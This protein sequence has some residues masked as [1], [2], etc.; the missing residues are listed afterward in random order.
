[1]MTIRQNVN[2]YTLVSILEGL[3]GRHIPSR[4]YLTIIMH[5]IGFQFN[6]NLKIK[7]NHCSEF[8]I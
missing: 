2:V 1:M 3:F 7:L 5:R 8:Q 4:K 6:Y